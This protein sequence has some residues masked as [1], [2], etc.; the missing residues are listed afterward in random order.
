MDYTPEAGAV[1]R[2]VVGD[3]ATGD[4]VAQEYAR[5]FVEPDK[6]YALPEE[7]AFAG[8]GEKSPFDYISP[9]QSYTLPDNLATLGSTTSAPYEAINQPYVLPEQAANAGRP[10]TPSPLDYSNPSTKYTLPASVGGGGSQGLTVSAP[11]A[12]ARAGTGSPIAANITSNAGSGAFVGGGGGGG[13]AS[14]GGGGG[15]MSVSAGGGG[16]GSAPKATS[17]RTLGSVNPLDF[18]FQR[19]GGLGRSSGSSLSESN[20]TVNFGRPSEYAFDVNPLANQNASMNPN[21]Y[22]NYLSQYKQLFS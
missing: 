14:F 3:Q 19:I 12:A 18:N 9:I 10:A 7:L 20:R 16:G 22:T 15:G 11:V 17:S 21:S 8:R 4:V 13:I 6:K 2:S 5:P 1:A